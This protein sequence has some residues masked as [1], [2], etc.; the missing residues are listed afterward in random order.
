MVVH[1]FEETLEGGAVVQVLARMNLEAQVDALFVE[2]IEDRPPATGQLGEAFLDQP[3]R[4]LRPGIEVG[5]QQGAG[6]GAVR[7]EAQASAGAGGELELLLGPVAPC[8]GAAMQVSGSEAVEQFVEGGV[9]RHQLPLKVGGKLADR[10][11]CLGAASVQLVTVIL[12]FGGEF[13]V[14]QARVHGRHL[15]AAIP[16]R[17]GPAGDRVEI[18]EGRAIVEKLGE[19]ERRSLDA[20]VVRIRHVVVSASS[21]RGCSSSGVHLAVLAWL[22]SNASMKAM[23]RRPSVM[24]GTPTAAP[25]S[26]RRMAQAKSR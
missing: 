2:D 14:D 7:P 24:P 25:R 17:G 5:P 8:I 26:P 15:H 10:H 21:W 3:R 6:E 12:A 23:P 22:F 11:A 19:K 13:E 20:M 1:G 4:A 18:V 9:H 16:Q